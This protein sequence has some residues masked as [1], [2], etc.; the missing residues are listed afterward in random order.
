MHNSGG[1]MADRGDRR[2]GAGPDPTVTDDATL[3]IEDLAASDETLS[4]PAGDN[5]TAERRDRTAIAGYRIVRL[6]GEGGM[7]V[8]WEAEQERPRRRVALKVMRR[9]HVVDELHARLFFREAETLA[10]LKHPNIAAIYESF[11]CQ[12]LE[13]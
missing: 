4:A 9:D 7:G 13:P 5:S 12:A 1:A 6:L 11:W 10:R 8:V 3:S 2:D